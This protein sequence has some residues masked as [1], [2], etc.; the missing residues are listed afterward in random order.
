M[1]EIPVNQQ[2]QRP[3]YLLMIHEVPRELL[4][5]CYGIGIAAEGPIQAQTSLSQKMESVDND[6][7]QLVWEWPPCPLLF[8]CE[9]WSQR[10]LSLGMAR[11]VTRMQYDAMKCIYIRSMWTKPSAEWCDTQLCWFQEIVL[12]R[13]SW[14]FSLWKAVL[15][16]TLQIILVAVFP[17]VQGTVFLRH[18]FWPIMFFQGIT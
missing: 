15:T 12:Y 14:F 6:V 5:G 8:W 16:S 1:V 18:C 10:K 4:K 3:W 9:S 17:Q 11:L 7:R 13:M 2:V